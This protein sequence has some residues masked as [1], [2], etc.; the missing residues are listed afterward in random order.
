MKNTLS[1]MNYRNKLE[2]LK[3]EKNSLLKQ[4]KTEKQNYKQLKQRVADLEQAREIVREAAAKTQEQLQYHISDITSLALD[5]VFDDPYEL[6]VEFVSRRNKTECDLFFRRKGML[7]DPLES[8]GYGTVDVASL[9][10]RVASWAMKEDK[11]RATVILDEPLRYLSTDHQQSASHML[12]EL[13]D[14]LGLQLIII[15]HE[16]I[17]TEHADKEIKTKIKK[18]VTYVD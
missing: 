11:P 3:G 7:I 8:S 14:K 13:A 5:I 2:Q 1:L 6:V 18:Q 10:L 15:T 9:S 16:P 17:L 12:K 4:L